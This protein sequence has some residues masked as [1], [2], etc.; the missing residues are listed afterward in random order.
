MNNDYREKRRPEN[1]ELRRRIDR[2]LIE[3]SNFIEKNF[4]DLGITDYRYEMSEAVEEL[5]LDRETVFQLVEDYIIQILKA[6]I[7]FY[8]YIHKLKVDKLENRPLDYTDIRNLAH[9]NLGVVRNLRIKDAEM[10]LKIIMEEDDLD[11][12]RLC[13]KA[14]EMSAVKLNPLCAYETLKLIQVKNSL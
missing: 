14:L 5:S 8:E 2:L 11:Y 4:S 9:K 3:G 12:L 10:L 7:I 6:K 13:V 1:A